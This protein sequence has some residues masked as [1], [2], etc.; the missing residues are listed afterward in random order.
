MP[1]AIGTD[2]EFERVNY[3]TVS[4]AFGE[5][6]D[7]NS[8]KGEILVLCWV[9]RV[10]ALSAGPGILEVEAEP[11]LLPHELRGMLNGGL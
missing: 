2:F 7:V 6:I 3:S 10:L 5:L 4:G 9:I 11:F 8:S 1:K